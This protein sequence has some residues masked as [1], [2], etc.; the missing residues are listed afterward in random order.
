MLLESCMFQVSRLIL[1]SW[2]IIGK[3]QDQFLRT[4][5]QNSSYVNSWFKV[6]FSICGTIISLLGFKFLVGEKVFVNF[7]YTNFT[8]R[9]WGALPNDTTLACV[10]F[11]YAMKLPIL[12][13]DSLQH[14]QYHST[15]L[16]LRF[17]P[18]NVLYVFYLADHNFLLPKRSLPKL[19]HTPCPTIYY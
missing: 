6:I 12:W 13:C 16:H 11:M 19:W 15:I 18:A 9:A 10:P 8:S 1:D 14:A 4:G 17:S 3:I 5:L 2:N 7:Q